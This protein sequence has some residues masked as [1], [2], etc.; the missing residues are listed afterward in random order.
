MED[1][2]EKL[3]EK[4][5]NSWVEEKIKQGFHSPDQCQSDNHKSYLEA[6]WEN[7]ERMINAG[8]NPKFYKWCDHCHTDMYPYSQLPEHIKEYERVTVETV[9]K[10]LVKD[11]LNTL[12]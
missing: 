1:L 4:V 10:C 9:L 7:Q 3:S 8:I 6:S 2:I 12:I 11:M 5:H